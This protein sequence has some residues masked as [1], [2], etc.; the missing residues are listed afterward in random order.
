[1]VAQSTGFLEVQGS[2]SH[3]YR[4]V[5]VQSVT[6][7]AGMHAREGMSKVSFGYDIPGPTSD[8]DK[9]INHYETPRM[10]YLRPYIG[11][12]R[13]WS[14]KTICNHGKN[15]QPSRYS[16]VICRPFSHITQYVE[17][18]KYQLQWSSCF[19]SGNP[20]FPSVLLPSSGT[21]ENKP[22]PR[23]PAMRIIKL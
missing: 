17:S 7:Y 8:S 9:E 22:S 23:L 19:V 13:A 12:W 16:I 14:T 20:I 3:D 18:P 6:G 21:I 4:Y 5:N 11:Q 10:T 1:M 15:W 2:D